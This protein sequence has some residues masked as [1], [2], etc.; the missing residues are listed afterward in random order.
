MNSVNVCIKC[1]GI[2]VN[3]RTVEHRVLEEECDLCGGNGYTGQTWKGV[4]EPKDVV[5][6]VEAQAMLLNV[7]KTQLNDDE[8]EMH[9]FMQ[10]T[11]VRSHLRGQIGE[12]AYHVLI[13]CRNLAKVPFQQRST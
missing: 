10:F 2:G 9:L 6:E 3:K 5:D 4:G 1:G 7:V 8:L 11:Q 13:C 12:K